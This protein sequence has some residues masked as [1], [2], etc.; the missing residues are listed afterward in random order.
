D[1]NDIMKALK[2]HSINLKYIVLTH[3]HFDHIGAVVQLKNATNAKIYL[4]RLDVELT[5]NP[6]LS[7][8]IFAGDYSEFEA[9]SPDV[10]LEDEYR[11][12]LD[13]LIFHTIH[14]P[15]HTKG[16]CVFT[17]EDIMFS[18]DTLFN[19]SVGRTDL[20]GG[21]QTDMFSS[22]KKLAQIRKDFTVLPGHGEKTKLSIQRNTNPYM[23]TNYDN[24]F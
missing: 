8:S 9:F 7:L 10:I 21:N 17:L 6:S 12:S 24:I 13:E 23:G 15:G 22:A 3:G 20:Y 4:H 1:F 14:T 5:K 18:G 11:F 2:L 19:G 16:S